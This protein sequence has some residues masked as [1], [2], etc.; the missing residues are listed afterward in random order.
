MVND[1]AYTAALCVALT[2]PHCIWCIRQWGT[3]RL[4]WVASD[5]RYRKTVSFNISIS[6]AYAVFV[7]DGDNINS[8][9]S[10]NV[11]TDNKTIQV[12][13]TYN[14]GLDKFYWFAITK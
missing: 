2:L 13:N 4:E 8:S 12:H 14:G 3:N 5:S 1:N 9:M 7:E 11:Y 10:L 6:T